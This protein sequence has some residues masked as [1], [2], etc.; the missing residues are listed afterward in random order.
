MKKLDEL[1]QADRHCDLEGLPPANTEAKRLDSE[2]VGGTLQP[3][4]ETLAAFAEI[5]RGE[6]KQFESVD[7]LFDD[8]DAED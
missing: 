3:N 4:A 6:G 7:A 2:L 1:K 5:E 8:L